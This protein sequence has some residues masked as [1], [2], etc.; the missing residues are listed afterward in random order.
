MVSITAPGNAN[1]GAFASSRILGG[2]ARRIKHAFQ[3]EREANEG[4]TANG[5]AARVARHEFK[6]KV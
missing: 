5:D 4:Q 3:Y 2:A 1:T 6:E